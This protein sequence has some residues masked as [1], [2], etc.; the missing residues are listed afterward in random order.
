[1]QMKMQ[2]YYMLVWC[3]IAQSFILVSAHPFYFV[4][5]V[6]GNITAH[7]SCV[8]LCFIIHVLTCPAHT[9]TLKNDLVKSVL[10]STKF[11]IQL[12]SMSSF[13]WFW[14]DIISNL[15][16]THTRVW[17]PVFDFLHIMHRIKGTCACIPVSTVF[18]CP[19]YHQELTD[20]V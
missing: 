12:L 7:H 17:P 8:F 6:S 3:S 11:C 18:P 14:I 1:M 19:A 9:P 5:L 2:I 15:F 10:A 4:Q 13:I 20:H 16:L